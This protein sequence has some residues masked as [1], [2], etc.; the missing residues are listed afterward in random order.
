VQQIELIHPELGSLMAR[1]NRDAVLAALD[2]YRRQ[3]AA[4]EQLVAE[5]RWSDLEGQLSHCQQLR[6][7][8]L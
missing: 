1:C 5:Q 4:L 7:D 2:L 6:P 3:L 8:F